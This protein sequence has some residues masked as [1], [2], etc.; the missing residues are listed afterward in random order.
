MV[1]T[2]SRAHVHV[3]AAFVVHTLIYLQSRGH[4]QD[5]DFARRC[6]PEDIVR[7]EIIHWFGVQM[8][9][10]KLILFPIMSM[11]DRKRIVLPNL[12]RFT[13]MLSRSLSKLCRNSCIPSALAVCYI[14][15]VDMPAGSIQIPRGL[16]EFLS[17]VDGQGKR[18]EAYIS[19]V[20][21]VLL[22]KQNG[23]IGCELDFVGADAND[24]VIGA[25]IE[26]RV[27]VKAFIA[28][29]VAKANANLAGTLAAQHQTAAPPSAGSAAGGGDVSCILLLIHLLQFQLSYC[30]RN[31]AGSSPRNSRFRCQDTCQLGR[32]NQ[33][34]CA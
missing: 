20:A 29:A 34:M 28:R 8:D 4:F 17:L 27:V 24:M 15:C 11:N 3:A 16:Y 10:V 21:T 2:T 9:I 12:H 26:G 14:V 19:R 32:A 23:P 18:D 5:G 30:A 25:E 6:S 33:G 22:D 13:R 31:S 7:V 1:V